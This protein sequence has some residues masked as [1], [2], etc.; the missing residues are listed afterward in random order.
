M[1]VRCI[2]LLS[3]LLVLEACSSGKFEPVPE[4]VDYTYLFN[5]KNFAIKKLKEIGKQGVQ[6]REL[7]SKKNNSSAFDT[8]YLNATQIDWNYYTNVLAEIDMCD[9]M[10]DKVYNM[11]QSLDSF[12]QTATVTYTPLYQ[13]LPLTAMTLIF[14]VQT[15]EINSMYAEYKKVG[16][17][18]TTY[19]TITYRYNTLLQIVEKRKP[20]FG[21]TQAYA[22]QL[23]FEVQP[24]VQINN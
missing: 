3:L 22:R 10:Y 24:S 7:T 11:Q 21:S 8:A 23:L 9:S 16:L 4:G 5:T 6:L 12:A 1:R 15:N 20:M 18:S 19:K 17:W 13:N 14:N 2:W